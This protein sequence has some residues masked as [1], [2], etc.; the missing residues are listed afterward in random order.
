M[1]EPVKGELIDATQLYTRLINNGYKQGTPIR[2]I[3]C[4]SSSKSTGG[5]ARLAKIL[6]AKVETP[7]NRFEY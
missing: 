4:H 1:F 2:L 5:A 6:E 7:T 3:S